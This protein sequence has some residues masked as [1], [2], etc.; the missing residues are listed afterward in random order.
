M[1]RGSENLPEGPFTL[2]VVDFVRKRAQKNLEKVKPAIAEALGVDV[3]S[4]APKL[5]IS[6]SER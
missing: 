2:F 4:I 5:M 6:F 3:V 1:A